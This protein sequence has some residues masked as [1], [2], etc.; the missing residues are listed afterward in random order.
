MSHSLDDMGS[1]FD[2]KGNLH[3]WWTAED[4]HKFDLKVKN[5]IK[6]YETFAAYDGIKMDGSLSTGENLADISGL[7]ICMEYLR[8]F[9]KK[10]SD[11]VPIKSLSFQAF[12]VYIALQARQ[13]IFDKAI[14]AQLKVNPHPMDKYRT[15]CPLARLELFRS[16]YNIKKGDKMYWE[17]T[18]TIW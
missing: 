12:F 1:K 6:Q 4:R 15:N 11:I 9:Q 10:N 16:L 18:D 17:S 7:A 2:Y 8:D 13:K 5:V 3:N 14:K